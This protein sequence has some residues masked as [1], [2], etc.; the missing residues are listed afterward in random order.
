MDLRIFNEQSLF[1]AM[2]ELNLSIT[3]YSNGKDR[4]LRIESA[5]LRNQI[6]I[7]H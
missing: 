4:S 1:E 6:F 5:I 3:A 7:K 2:K